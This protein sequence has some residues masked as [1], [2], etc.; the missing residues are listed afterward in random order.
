MEPMGSYKGLLDINIE[1]LLFKG[2]F[3]GS[4][5]VPLRDPIRDLVFLLVRRALWSLS[6]R[7]LYAVPHMELQPHILQQSYIQ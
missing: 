7:R 3:K 5:G 1:H 2:S 6:A 4:I